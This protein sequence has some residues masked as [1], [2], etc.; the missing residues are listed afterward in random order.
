MKF[1]DII[2]LPPKIRRRL[3]LWGPKRKYR[4]EKRRSYSSDELSDYLRRHDIRSSRLLMARRKR[5]DPTVD[6]FRKAFGSW[7]NAVEAAF[8][9]APFQPDIDEMYVVKAAVM[10]DIRTYRDY[11]KMRKAHPDV[12]PSVQFVRSR[13][14]SVREFLAFVRWVSLK[15]TV[16]GYMSLWRKLGRRP[17]VD[18]CTTAGLHLELPMKFFQGKASFDDFVEGLHKTQEKLSHA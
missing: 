1:D 15:Q 3:R 9:K 18:D 2:K 5:G 7:R 11:L 14:S 13:F 8:G 4:K 6:D 12:L 10:Y 17:L 16:D